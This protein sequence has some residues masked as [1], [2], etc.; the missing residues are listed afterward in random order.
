MMEAIA[1]RAV[2]SH[3]VQAR[4]DALATEATRLI[5]RYLAVSR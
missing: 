4:R 5:T 1:H 3:P 2:S